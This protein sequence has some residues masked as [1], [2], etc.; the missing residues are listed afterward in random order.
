MPC[1]PP[2]HD[3][4]LPKEPVP[5]LQPVPRLWAVVESQAFKNIL[6]DEMDMMV[7]RAATVIQ[8]NWKGYRLRQK[9]ISQMMAAKGIQEAWR[10]FST[11][12]LV[13]SNRPTVR[14]KVKEDEGDIPY[15]PPQQVRFHA[16]EDLLPAV[17]NKETQL[18]SSNNLA[19][20][21]LQSKAAPG[22]CIGGAARGGLAPQQAVTGRLSGPM[23]LGPK[24]QHCMLTKTVR[25]SCLIRQ[26]EGDTTKGSRSTKAGI[27]EQVASVRSGQA[28]PG[29]MKTQTQVHTEADAPKALPHPHP[30]TKTPIKTYPIVSTPKSPATTYTAP[31]VAPQTCPT[32]LVTVTKMQSLT[33]PVSPMTK[34]PAHI[35]L[36]PSLSNT[37]PQ[38]CSTVPATR[39]P[40]QGYVVTPAV[41]SPPRPGVPVTRSPM[42]TGPGLVMVKT[43]PQTH[44]VTAM[45]RSH[46]QTCPDMSKTSSQSAPITKPSPQTRLV[47][48]ITKTPAQIRSVAAVLRTLCLVPTAAAKSPK[49]PPQ[50]PMATGIPNATFQDHL[51]SPKAKATMSTKQTTMVIRAASQLYMANGKG[52]CSLHRHLDTVAPKHPVKTPLEAE[53]TKP[54]PPRPLKRDVA[55]KTNRTAV[56]RALSWTKVTE[57]RTKSLAQVQQKAEVVKVH[58]KVYMPV[59]MTVTLSQAQ[60]A[61]PLTKASSQDQPATPQPQLQLATHLTQAPPQPCPT[62][63]LTMVPPEGRHLAMCPSTTQPSLPLALS[64]APSPAQLITGLAKAPQAHLP[65]GL[66]KGQSQAQP[67]TETAKCPLATH[68]ASNLAGKTQSQ[69]LLSASKASVQFWQHFGTLSTGP[70]TKSDDRG[71]TQAHGHMQNKATQ[72]SRSVATDTQGMLLPLLTPTGHSVCSTDP[73]GDSGRARTPPPPP[74]P[75]QAVSCHDL[76]AS[77]ASLCAELV[78][79]LGSPEDLCA[80]LAKT[81]SQ[82]EVRPVLSQALSQEVLGASVVKALPQG[83]LG[84]ALMKALLWGELGV[85]L[86]QALSRG[87]LH[88]ELSKAT[89]GELAE[90]LCKALTDDERATL[91][92]A[93]CQGELGAVFTQ[94]LEQMAQRTGAFPLKATS[95]T[96]GSRMTAPAPV[97]VTCSGSLSVAWGPTLGPV[98]PQCSKGPVDTCPAAGQSWNSVDPSVAVRAKVGT[99]APRGMWHPTRG[100]GPWDP[101][102]MEALDHKPSAELLVSGRAMEKVIVQAAVTI[103]AGTRGYLVRRTI[104]VW[105]QRASVIQATW[106]GYRVRRN[107]VR[108]LRAAT[109]IQA[110]WRGYSIR[111]DQA[112]QAL[113]PTMWQES[114][115]RATGASNHRAIQGAD[116]S[117]EHRSFLSCQP[118]ICSVCQSLGPRVETPLRVVMLV[119]SQPRTCHVCGHTLS[120]RVVQG[121][122]QGISG[123]SGPQWASVSQQ[124][125]WSTWEQRAATIIQA[126]WRGYRTRHLL[127]QQ[128]SA[129]KMVQ[130]IWRGHYTRSCLTTDALLGQGGPWDIS[131]DTSHRASRAYS[132]HWPG[133]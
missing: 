50:P 56:T 45:T 8:A 77:I 49:V 6:V 59:E 84:M 69:P 25:S 26:L 133:V 92:Q 13:R 119:G 131:R 120:T 15:H 43:S 28:V 16:P 65:I 107:L 101:K 114:G 104:K 94:S 85:T 96:A 71:R 23:S 38:V 10:R 129:A 125:P 54:G 127:R 57:D 61:V 83:M 106:R 27:Q 11:R 60:L 128:Q 35:R 42:Q 52:K 109:V 89:Q 93:L 124:G 21:K 81:L 97:E 31:K 5:P 100:Q 113:L 12:R 105:H 63:V 87:E 55:P 91:S 18:P 73:W 110:T 112:R 121:F 122:G 53:K 108:L 132:I 33:C 102:R 4:C 130:A 2:Q 64:K 22:P 44:P 39:T 29:P 40:P 98:Q 1:S 123:R 88:P 7:S 14:K 70:H 103:Q 17:V 74:V 20:S 30:V 51:S 46:P 48:M 79:T 32:P 36:N 99:Q 3:S 76:A 86:S 95:K 58:A 78:A 116:K 111:R 82:V 47:A 67:A 34:P 117:S 115:G 66:T 80:L 41:K 24:H 62:S 90:V 9:L 118:D 68:S 19:S 37:I 75:S 72:N 126:T